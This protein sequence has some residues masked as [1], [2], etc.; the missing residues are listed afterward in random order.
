MS[1]L[2]FL[3]V[4]VVIFPLLAGFWNVLAAMTGAALAMAG[5][6]GGVMVVDDPV[7]KAFFLSQLPTLVL[8]SIISIRLATQHSAPDIDADLIS[9]KES[10][11]KFQDRHKE[12]KKAVISSEED[13]NR[14][15]QIYGVAKGLAESLSWKD[16]APRLTTGI[17]KIFG[18]YEFLLYAIDEGGQW[19]SLHRRG[20]WTKEPPLS[21]A[22]PGMVELIRPPQVMEV[23]PVLSI[24][25]FGVHSESN[26]HPTPADRQI[27]GALFLK[28][29]PDANPEKLTE[30]GKEFGAQLEMALD[31]A[32]LFSQM[33]MHSRVDGLTG[34][35]R[36]QA[37]MDR[38]DEEFKKAMAFHSIFCLLMVD[39][40]HFKRIN[41]THGHGAGDAVLVRLGQ[42]LKEAFYE[43]DVVGRYGGEEFI[44]LLPRAQRDGVMR[45][46][47]ALRHRI[48]QDEIV[49]GF[50]RL[51]ITVSIGLADYPHKGHTADQLIASADQALYHAKETGRNR[52]IA[53]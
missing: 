26:D 2:I 52:I 53:A 5:L 6:L 43:T 28:V 51:K 3:I 18:A 8:T 38:L 12:L 42:I 4:L 10:L 1:H 20:G 30:T 47:E 24:P 23:L 48:E 7:I 40:D 46:A 9:D 19:K 25:I 32:L 37:F 13:E 50:E 39:I 11:R 22:L 34:V 27:K 31:K 49:S 16:M 35:L 45:K 36:R 15:L 41:D 44:V 29:P 17:Q 33:E 21:G 14:S